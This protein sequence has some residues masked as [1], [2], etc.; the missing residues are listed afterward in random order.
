MCN[1][2]QQ[3]IHVEF[4]MELQMYQNIK[5]VG[6]HETYGYEVC[7]KLENY[8]FEEISEGSVYPILVRL[9]KKNQKNLYLLGIKLRRIL[10]VYWRD[11]SV[12]GIVIEED[13]NKT[14]KQI[15]Q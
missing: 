6:D 8:G 10:K 3:I 1:T 2:K 5:I 11:N 13:E 12:S 9:E 15:K 4:K 7:E 14:T